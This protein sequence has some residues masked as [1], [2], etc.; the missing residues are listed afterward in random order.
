MGLLTTCDVLSRVGYS[1]YRNVVVVPT[2]EVL[3][4][5]DDVAQYDSSAQRVEDVFVVRVQYQA[6]SY[7]T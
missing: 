1:Y 4:S 6:F 5:R 3:S 2:K 7:S